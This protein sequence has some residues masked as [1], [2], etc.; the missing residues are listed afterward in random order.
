MAEE[1]ILAKRLFVEA[2]LQRFIRFG[3]SIFI[4]KGG[5]MGTV[6]EKAKFWRR[7]EPITIYDIGVLRPAH[8][9]KKQRFETLDDTR[10]ESRRSERL[11][12]PGDGSVSWAAQMLHECRMGYHHCDQPYCP[13]CARRFRRWLTGELLRITENESV[14]ILTVLL[15]A[16]DRGDL[17]CLQLKPFKHMLR[18]RLQRAGLGETPVVGGFEV[19]YRAREKVWMFH[20][21]LVI[22]GG[23][24]EAI[25]EFRKSFSGG[26][27]LRPVEM[28]DLKNPSE[29]LSYV[30]KFTTY[31]RPHQRAGAARQRAV[32]LNR[33]EHVEL[34]EWM[35]RFEF[36]EYLFLFNVRRR[37][38]TIVACD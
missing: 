30:L 25:T 23:D 31:H 28:V 14:R 33:R 9:E 1:T 21:N 11:M 17:N 4:R 7:G 19:V 26:D 13:M 36:Q 34:V 12:Q 5:S 15:K 18:K 22:I 16:V 6:R 35:G 32:P 8:L 24:D 2:D 29:Q 10:A 38:A 37:G 20:I 3:V 27:I